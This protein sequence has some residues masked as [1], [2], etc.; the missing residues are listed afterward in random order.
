MVLRFRFVDG[1]RHRVFGLCPWVGHFVLLLHS[2]GLSGDR[3]WHC[4]VRFYLR[5]RIIQSPTTI[6]WCSAA[7]GPARDVGNINGPDDDDDDDERGRGGFA[8]PN[9][10]GRR[11][12]FAVLSAVVRQQQQL[13]GLVDLLNE[14]DNDSTCWCRNKLHFFI[15]FFHHD[16]V[17]TKSALLKLEY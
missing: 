15:T 16:A 5:T 3:R 9:W 12:E 11:H 10:I 17:E 13:Q 7:D 8:G 14:D 6:R 4:R 2:G 1:C